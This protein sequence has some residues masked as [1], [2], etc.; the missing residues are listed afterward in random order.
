MAEKLE[1]LLLQARKIEMSVPEW[2][3]HRRSFVY[4]NTNIENEIITRDMVEQ[5]DQKHENQKKEI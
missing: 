4:G 1:A 3:E 5:A 2:R